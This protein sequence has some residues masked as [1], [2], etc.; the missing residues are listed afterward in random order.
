MVASLRSWLLAVA[1]TTAF[2]SA[3]AG[4]AQTL[5]T[6]YSP[7]LAISIP[8]PAGW[9]T[10]IGSQ[11]GFKMQIFT[12]PS[13]DVPERPG[14]RVQVMTG[15]IP[16]GLTVDEIAERY[17]EGQEVSVAR[18]YSLHGFAGKTWYFSSQDGAERSRLMLTPIEGVLYGIYAH[19]EAGTVESY[20]SVLDAMWD[21]FSVEREPFFQTYSRPELSLQF[22]YPRSWQRTKSLRER[23]KILFRCVPQPGFSQRRSRDQHPRDA[24]SQRVHS[25]PRNNVGGVLH[26]AGGNV[27]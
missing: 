23:G 3:C 17:I 14:I 7:M 10:E 24:G 11:A 8:V 16:N 19:G 1:V 21:Q 9:S 4:V 12:G 27:G 22:R 20:G 15:P 5:V 6:V 25:S 26:G 2:F 18:G 13:V